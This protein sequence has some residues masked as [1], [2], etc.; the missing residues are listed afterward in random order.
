MWNKGAIPG[1]AQP[2]IKVSIGPQS[3]GTVSLLIYEWNDFENLGMYDERV[4][5]IAYICDRLAISHN[6]CKSSQ[7]GQFITHIPSDQANTTSVYTKTLTL[8]GNE[9]EAALYKVDATG[10][11]CV[12]LTSTASTNQTD[13]F[14][15]AWV[16]WKFPYGELPAT[17]Y[18]KL[19]LYGVFAFVYLA[20]GLFWFVQSF[21]YWSD[22][23]PV[24]HFLSAAIFYLVVEMAFN[25]G[26]WEAYNQ[27]GK[28]SYGLL[29]LV[30]LLNAGRTSMSFFMLLIVCMG[31]SVV[32]PSLGHSMKYC[33]ILACTHFGCGVIYTL[34][35][36]LLSPETAGFLILLV[37][38]P[39]S[40]TMTIFY[41][42]TLNSITAT[43]RDLE[44][45][46]QH[47][48]ILMY[49]RL[50]RLLVF[51][52]VA[53]VLIFILNMFAYSDSVNL[54]WAAKSW[55]FRWIMLD[56]LLNIL[57]FI[58]FFV[59]VILWRPTNNNARYGLMQISQDEEEALDLEERLRRAE[60]GDEY[61]HSR[62]T[63]AERHVIDES[64]VFELGEELTDEEEDHQP[65]NKVELSDVS[66][67]N[68]YNNKSQGKG[69]EQS[70]LLH[71]DQDEDEDD[72]HLDDS[73]HARLTGNARRL[74]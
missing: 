37:I 39:L 5:D 30:A 1:G 2:Y 58:V 32:K 69:G 27:T 3:H 4:G 35:T 25:F 48:K 53:V 29:A 63:G 60:E 20:V 18:P 52:V 44:L 7:L 64:A 71:V 17:D 12:A 49:K 11:Y 67:N 59:I 57:Y 46:K 56:G 42:W 66:K 61:G 23:L 62:N 55:K 34:G 26:Y 68:R 41:V 21:R 19:L 10:Y 43:I 31:Y 70:A 65:I 54:D 9:T 51:S 6:L 73:E 45:R 22:I 36:M 13:S 16:E 38:F 40:I 28:A 15:E 14:F 72:D 50:Y 8:S 47:V 33:I 24:Q 74:T